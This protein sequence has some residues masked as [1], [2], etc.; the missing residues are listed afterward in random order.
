MAQS[1]NVAT[2]VKRKY[3]RPLESVLDLPNLIEIQTNSYEWFIREG[4]KEVLDEVSPIVDFSGNQYSLS[5]GNYYLDEP[6]YS[7]K[8]S[9]KKKINY[10]A[11]LKVEVSLKNLETGKVKKQE[12][13]LSDLPLMTEQGT[14][15]I[16]GVERVIISQLVRSAGVFFT[17]EEVG[18]NK[19]FGA[20]VIPGRGAWLELETATNGAIYAKI[21]RRRK[22]PI[23]TLVRAF[24]ASTDEEI[25]KLFRDVNTDPDMNYIEATLEKDVT[26]NADEAFIE[27]YKKI[28]PGDLATAENARQLIEGMFFDF[29][30]Y[31]LSRVGRYKMNRMLGFD[32][33]NKKENRI[34]RKEDFIA[35]V[36]EVIKR[37]VTQGEATDIDHLA[38]RRVRAVGELLQQRFRVG[39][40]RAERNIKDR[41]STADP[42]VVS[43]SSL[44]NIRP[45]SSVIKEF[46][47]SSQLSQFMD[48]TNPLSELVNKRRLSALGPG[49]LSKERAGFDVRDV[50]RTHYGRI[51][52][53]ETPEGPNIG[54]VNYLASYARVNEYGFLETPYRK[55]IGRVAND[56]KAAEGYKMG[57]TITGIGKK[58]E[59]ITKTIAGKIAK[60]KDLKEIKVIP[61]VTKEVEYLTAD[62]EE[63]AVIA[64][65]NT[66]ITS[67][68]HFK[69]E[70]IT[71]RK[72][73]EAAEASI[74]EVT[75]MDVASEQIVSVSTGLVP[76]LEHDDGKRNLMAA[77][78][79]RQAVPLLAPEAPIVG[80]GLEKKVAKDS[81]LTIF[82]PE[83]GKVLSVT[84][85]TLKVR[86]DKRGEEL[87]E[88][89]KYQRTNDDTCINQRAVVEEGHR[90]KKGDVLIDGPAAEG[91]EL[92]I[93][94]NLLVAYM[95]F[96]GYN[97][98]DAIIISERLVKEDTYS[99]VHLELFTIDVRD[100]KLGA[101]MV[102]RDIP[103]VSEES[104]RNLDED[105]IIRI[106]AEVE[107]GDILV[108]K[109]TPKGET[110]LSAEERLLRAIFGEKA[111]DVKDTSLRVQ[112]G[113]HGKV[114]D[115]SARERDKGD[116]LPAG[117]IKQID[118]LVAKLVKITVGD[119]MANRHGN[120]GVIARIAPVEDMPYL[121]D[122][123]P[124]D[125]V[126]NPLGVSARMNVGQI[127]ETHLGWAA[128]ALG[129]KVASPVFM[130]PSPEMIKEELRNAGLPEDGKTVLYD[131]RTG[132]AFEERV[133]VGIT[134]VLKLHH[135]V[136]DK[137]HARSIGSYA[138]VT[139]QPLGGKA[140]FGGQRFGEMEVWALEAYGAAHTL[141]EVL[142]IKSDDV[143]GR[144]RA[145]EAII[146]GDVITE[147]R[148]P[149]SF[150]VL[151][152]ELQGLG[153]AIDL[154]SDVKNEEVSADEVIE[155]G[156]EEGIKDLKDSGLIEGS[157]AANLPKIDVEKE[158]QIDEFEAI[159]EDK[160]AK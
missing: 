141:Q 41:M 119:K 37:N 62:V 79:Q 130:G 146:K 9:R 148:V 43:P 26:T 50:H 59:K 42:K 101:E 76:F 4:I 143:L 16:N 55:V 149:E 14:F 30:K 82:A 83:P 56:G 98:E 95:A 144:S 81:G 106:G 129:I 92:A 158:A 159:K 107:P 54:L 40:L 5:F 11:P 49:G 73:G 65:A 85:A 134:Y 72:N 20:K 70:L 139:Q 94:Q 90:F 48:Q 33:P 102:T 132:D 87:I 25:K 103:N 110:E 108:G 17:A 69:N 47:A 51:C 109:I 104:L 135:M 10:E 22:I 46:F 52:P 84:G 112:P 80:T 63:A 75:Y 116:D 24:G 117:V 140:Q 147:P 31:D 6:K 32:V 34:L 12:V 8:D 13:F 27:I 152:K 93:G 57:E 160:D 68:G 1:S 105:G 123:T 154:L 136:E 150:N 142:T 78:M 145:Y 137:I 133:T 77:N 127:L 111:R 44:I 91:G 67:D 7:E 3:Y 125:M 120:K 153:L 23:T 115:V 71:V 138:M 28:R 118:V 126:L 99:S 35:I 18:G 39:V 21:D 19:F 128:L 86:F 38:N 64:Q 121:A 2:S 45:I 113:V 114:V 88:L 151:V 74:D 58:G 155:E 96:S 156:Y 53:N 100:T 61:V 124:V 157:V 36:K 29:K 97:Y 15:I 89:K 66:E 60:K 131:G 122:G